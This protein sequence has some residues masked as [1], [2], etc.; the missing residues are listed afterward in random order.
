MCHPT[1]L[2]CRAEGHSV[3]ECRRP[4]RNNLRNPEGK[5]KGKDKGKPKGKRNALNAEW[6][7]EDT[8][9]DP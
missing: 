4:R 9:V 5:K 3:V 6:V 1:C 8:G 2:R 7:K